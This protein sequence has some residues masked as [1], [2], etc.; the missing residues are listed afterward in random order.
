MKSGIQGLILAFIGTLTIFALA[1]KNIFKKNPISLNFL[2]EKTI[3]EISEYFCSKSSSDLNSF[4]NNTGPF[5]DYKPEEGSSFVKNIIRDFIADDPNNKQEIGIQEVK[6]YFSESPL[7]IFVLVIFCILVILWIP[8]TLCIC[9]KCCKCIPESCLKS[10][11]CFVFICILFCAVVLINCFIGYSQNG[12]IVDGVF[13]LGCSILKVEQHL[14]Y[15]DEYKEYKPYWIGLSGIIEKLQETKDNITSLESK[16]EEIKNINNQIE[17]TFN[18]LFENY[19]NFL[20]QE[21]DNRIENKE[22]IN[23]DP[24]SNGNIT[25]NFIINEY[26]PPET[27]NTLLNAIFKEIN[28]L[29]I[30][31]YSKIKDALDSIESNMN[32]AIQSIKDTGIAEDIDKI[33]RDLD[34]SINDIENSIIEKINDYYDDFDKFSSKSREYINIFFSINLAIVVIVGVSLVLLCLCNK[35]L[36][37]LCISWFAMYCFMLL[38]FFLGGTFGL[39]GSFTQEASYAIDYLSENLNEIN[40][41]D[42]Q[43]REISHI[44]LNGNGSLSQSSI[45]PESFNFELV[46]GI[47]SSE[48]YESSFNDLTNE[49]KD[50]NP[51]SFSINDGKYSEVFTNM[52]HLTDLNTALEDVKKYI[53]YSQEDTYVSSSTEIYDEWVIFKDDCNTENYEYLNNKKLRN[54]VTING[55]CLVITEWTEKEI[56]NRY[57]DIQS[58][59]ANVNIKDWAL[60]YYRSITGYI[61]SYKILINKIKKINNALKNDYKEIGFKEIYETKNAVLAVVSPLIESYNDIVGS[62]SIFEILN[63]QFLKRDVNKIMEEL[64]NDFGKT[65]K[66]TSTLLLII[67]IFELGMTLAILVI[68]KGFKLQESQKI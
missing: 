49:M 11:K 25:P 31:S 43:V 55:K 45:V 54:L 53:D 19:T 23:P 7:Y 16:V 10:P 24:N 32:D 61:N 35:G 44:C 37:I 8:Y 58:N 1:K 33:C 62:N 20:Q 30:G 50:Y 39:I 42:E 29:K 64:Y 46:D 65:F 36:S 67:S 3:D 51:V 57:K 41:M 59:N 60:K 26:G 9:C 27:E 40:N 5:Y 47:Y 48:N 2:T 6:D 68:M 34:S 63:C 22:V 4:Y 18:P 21:Y 38:T 14:K 13:G 52:D 66:D 17:S 28:L 56:E 15:G 12:S